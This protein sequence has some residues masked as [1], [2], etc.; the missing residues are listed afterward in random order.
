[1]ETICGTLRKCMSKD[2]LGYC[3]SLEWCKDKKTAITNN[4]IC[5]YCQNHHSCKAKDEEI[6]TDDL[7]GYVI[8]CDLYKSEVEE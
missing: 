7:T 8:E 4:S 6:I 3:H 1:M 2:K 5:P